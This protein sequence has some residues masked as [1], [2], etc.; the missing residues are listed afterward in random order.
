MLT[1]RDEQ[2]LLEKLCGRREAPGLKRFAM[3]SCPAAVHL[4]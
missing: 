1:V 4:N 3:K 2:M